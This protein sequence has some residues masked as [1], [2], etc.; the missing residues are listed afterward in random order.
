MIAIGSSSLS[1][2]AVDGHVAALFFEASGVGCEAG[3]RPL[4]LRRLVI[5]FIPDSW[6]FLR[7]FTQRMRG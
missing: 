1:P 2:V 3:D 6:A 7:L 4:H 5:G